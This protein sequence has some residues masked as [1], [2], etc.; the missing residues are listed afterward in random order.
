MMRAPGIKE[1]VCT[2]ILLD[3]VSILLS[4]PD[5]VVNFL[6]SRHE[7]P[8]S[9]SGNAAKIVRFFNETKIR[10]VASSEMFIEHYLRRS[11][12]WYNSELWL[13]DLP[14]KVQAVV[15]LA[16]CDE[17]VNTPKIEKVLDLHNSKVSGKVCGGGARVEKIIWRDVGHAHCVSNPQRWSDIHH[18]LKRI[19]R[20]ED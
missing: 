10:L 19:D 4:D 15:A 13:Q 6:Y 12:A 20:K 7:I 17:I 14:A 2:F 18:A 11:F 16:E 5:V 8:D 1:R 3:P 9:Y